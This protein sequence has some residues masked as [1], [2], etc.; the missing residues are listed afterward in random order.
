MYRIISFTL[1]V[2]TLLCSA[3]TGNDLHKKK[4]EADLRWFKETAVTLPDNMLAKHCDEQM[5]P[6][7]TLLQR[8]LKMVIYVN[9]E[10][11]QD[12]RLM[13]LSRTYMFI[14]ENEYRKNFGV[15]LILNTPRMEATNHT[16]T[17]MRF[18]RTVFYDLDGS[19][20]RLNPHLPA[21]EG[22]HTFL[23]NEDNKVILVG[24]PAHSTKL[25]QQYLAALDK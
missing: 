12:C 25:K 14:L 21:N 4:S 9:Q 1:I 10:G 3:C 16:L 2:G 6:D 7:T 15:I 22:F 8:P 20:E 11:C 18:R 5:S 13:A 23:L 24:N 19:F 17:E